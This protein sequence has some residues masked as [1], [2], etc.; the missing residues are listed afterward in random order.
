MKLGIYV[1]MKGDETKASAEIFGSVTVP[2]KESH[3]QCN[4]TVGPFK[5]VDDAKR[6][7]KAMGQ[8]VACGEG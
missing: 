3:P 4:F 6:Y 5:T 8:G 2:T 1:G 7:V